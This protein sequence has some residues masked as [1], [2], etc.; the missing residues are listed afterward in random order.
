MPIDQ[1]TKPERTRAQQVDFMPKG[2]LSKSA[3]PNCFIDHKSV[4]RR[5]LDPGKGG[6]IW[7]LSDVGTK[8]PE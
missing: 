7:T 5:C 1:R 3:Q 6:G 8:C 4:E 2:G